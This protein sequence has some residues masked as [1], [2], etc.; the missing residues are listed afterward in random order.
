MQALTAFSSAIAT[1]VLRL[2]FFRQPLLSN[3]ATR[4]AG[5]RLV[6]FDEAPELR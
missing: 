2:T 4:K 3:K 5:R 1:K 6:A